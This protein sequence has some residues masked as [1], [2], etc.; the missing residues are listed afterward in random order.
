M[1][2]LNAVGWHLHFISKDRQ[3]GGH[4]LGI[5]VRSAEL[6]WDYTDNFTM[7]LPETGMFSGF[8]LT[9]DQSEDIRRVETDVKRD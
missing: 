1:K 5:N 7:L 4:V 6:S 3:Q 2:D 8:D 9:V